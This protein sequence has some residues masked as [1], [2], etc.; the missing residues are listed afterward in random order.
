MAFVDS[1]LLLC[2]KGQNSTKVS[3]LC[4][5]LLYFKDFVHGLDHP[6]METNPV[7]QHLHCNIFFNA[8][9]WPFE[10]ICGNYCFLFTKVLKLLQNVILN[11]LQAV[12]D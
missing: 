4:V 9:L 5:L 8:V 7:I 3:F 1:S 6:T 2:A 12:L 11:S 10:C